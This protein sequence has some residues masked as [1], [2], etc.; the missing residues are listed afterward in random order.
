MKIQLFN[1]FNKPKTHKD[2]EKELKYAVSNI[3]WTIAVDQYR[4]KVLQL[5]YLLNE[6][7]HLP[8]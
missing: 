6:L 1:G 7:P 8:D 3:D 5:Q 2:I 4:N